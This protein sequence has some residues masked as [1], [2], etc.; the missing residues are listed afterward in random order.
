MGLLLKLNELEMSVEE[1]VFRG[2]TY[3]ISL[4]HDYRSA[5]R[6]FDI[7]SVQWV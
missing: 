2:G 5:E 3:T 6:N 1:K 7:S 4:C